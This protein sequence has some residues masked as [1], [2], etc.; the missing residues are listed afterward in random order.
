MEGENRYE[1]AGE[2]NKIGERE[3]EKERKKRRERVRER[4]STCCVSC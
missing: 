2:R 3:Q 1:R 4:G